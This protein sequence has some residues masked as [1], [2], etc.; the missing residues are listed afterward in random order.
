MSLLHYFLNGGKIMD[1]DAISKAIALI[2]KDLG[3]ESV[4]LLGS[5]T[6]N[7]DIKRV[8]TGSITLDQALMGGIPLGRTVEIFGPEASGKT[9]VALYVAAEVQKMGRVAALVDVEHALDKNLA[10]SYGVDIEKMVISQPDTGEQALEI[11]DKLVKT[12]IVGVVILDSIAAL[13][14]EAEADADMSAQHMGLHGRMMSKALRKLTSSCARN[15]CTV[16]FINQIREKIGITWGNP[17]VTPGGRALKF[18]SSVR[19][20]VRRGE[21]ITDDQKNRIGHE[22][23]CYVVKNKTG[24]PYKRGNFL[25]RYGVGIDRI[26]ELV[27]VGTMAGIIEKGAAGRYKYVDDEGIEH[28]WHGEANVIAGITESEALQEEI[29]TKL[30][31]RLGR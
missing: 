5:D 3:E 29:K 24:T 30:I 20:D 14:P 26:H 31:D 28:K 6:A 18:Y 2:N 15:N 21:Y 19:I 16:I 23:K 25:L 12:G 22:V 27:T 4:M 8:S 9:T 11:T 1:M 7:H 13:L 17:E 10:A